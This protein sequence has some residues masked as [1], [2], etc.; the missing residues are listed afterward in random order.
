MAN[1]KKI[2]YIIPYN[3]L[4]GTRGPQGPKNFSDLIIRF[5]SEKHFLTLVII[6]PRSD[7]DELAIK[8]R[9]KD[10]VRVVFVK[11]PEGCALAIKKI[12]WGARL[13]PLSIGK[14]MSGKLN[15]LLSSEHNKYDIIN[16]DYFP[17]IQYAKCIKIS[18][19]IV[20]FCH[21]AYSIG[22]FRAIQKS[23][24]L[25]AMFGRLFRA[26]AFQRFEKNY[27]G[28]AD[29]AI[30]VSKIDAD[31]LIS[32]GLRNVAHMKIPVETV[33]HDA[34]IYPRKLPIEL[35]CVVPPSCN[36]YLIRDAINFVSIGVPAIRKRL[37][38]EISVTV[39]GKSANVVIEEARV[40]IPINYIRDVED[41]DDFMKRNWI[42]VYPQHVGS[43]MH[44]KVLDAFLNGLPVVGY[45]EIMSAF[46]GIDGVHYYSCN[47]INDICDAVIKLVVDEHLR[48]RISQN[49][50]KMMRDKY[51][52][53]TIG[54]FM[55]DLYQK[56]LNQN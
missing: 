9:Y 4:R 49:A 45:G 36:E 6:C 50:L 8:E 3:P 10:I 37:G 35:L 29:I 23:K 12:F 39:F 25:F 44:T 16:F 22:E 2:L 13:Y 21:D 20:L 38:Y 30:T 34:D 5:L 52:L 26:Y 56:L 18:A 55:D 15:N 54:S 24:S 40:D 28:C 43:G 1:V 31:C 46:D 19:P 51:N 42:Y 14:A 48:N 7:M 41:Y 27:Y 17:L 33:C 47:T 53:L 32:N 11:E